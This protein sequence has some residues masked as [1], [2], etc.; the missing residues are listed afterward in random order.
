MAE[1]LILTDPDRIKQNPEN[2]RLI[3]H[4][5]ELRDLEKSIE[6]QGILVPL[7]VYEEGKHYVL[8][9]GERRWRCARTLGLKRIPVLVQPKPDKLQNIMMMF[10]IHNA[11]R[12]WDPLPTA[13]KLADLEKLLTKRQGKKPTERELA[14]IASLKIGVVRRL[15]KL[16]AL[17]QSY[18]DE[19]MDELNKPRSKQV[20]TV[21]HVLEITRGTTALRKR[22]AIDTEESEERLRKALLAKVRSGVIISTVEARRLPRIARALDRE[23]ITGD[24][25]RRIIDRLTREPKYSIEDAFRDS[26]EQADYQHATAQTASRLVDRLE[27]HLKREYEATPDL[28]AVLERLRRLLQRF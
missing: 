8:L 6:Q 25:V 2:P 7:T 1:P 13:M 9:D 4:E 14:G 20:I 27:Q 15:K 24:R 21:D 12:D 3:F 10:A 26:V 5:D 11:Q 22:D 17:P 18:R 19:L 23:E 28:V 16:L